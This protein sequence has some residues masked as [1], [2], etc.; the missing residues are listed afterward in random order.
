MTVRRPTPR[1]LNRNLLPL[2]IGMIYEDRD[3]LVVDKPAGLLTMATAKEKRH[4]LYAM[5]FD[6]LKHR[7]PREQLFIVH[8]LDREASGLLV[9]AKSEEAKYRLQEQF[10]DHS[11]GRI[12][13]AVTE[14]RIDLPVFTIQSYLAEN[15]IYRCYSTPNPAAGKWAVTHGR[16]IQTS[17]ARTLV[18]L[19]LE[20]G[21][22]H[23]IRVH[24]AEQGHPIVGDPVYGH[25]RSPIRRMA[26]HGARLTFAHPFTG[27][28]LTFESPVPATFFGLLGRTARR[29]PPRSKCSSNRETDPAGPM[30]RKAPADRDGRPRRVARTCWSPRA[31]AGPDRPRTEDDGRTA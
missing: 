15:A 17:P 13:L 18:E 2:G 31:G 21:R 29:S 24:L 3:C 22:K 4:T 5:L 12:Y 11:A 20:T 26:L 28:I 16:V 9:F 6:L 8:R 25:G 10:K 14:G 30:A 27:E 23:Q 19:Q 7:R 1:R